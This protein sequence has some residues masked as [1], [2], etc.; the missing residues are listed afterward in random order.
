MQNFRGGDRGAEDAEDGTCVK[1]TGH[2][3]GNKIG[4]HALHHF[5][6]R[7]N[8]GDEI[9]PRRA[10]GCRIKPNAFRRNERCW[11]NAG[12]GMREHAE[13]VPLAAC[14]RHLGVGECRSA[15]R[16]L[17]AVHHNGRAVADARFFLGDQRNRFFAGWQLRAHQ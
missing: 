14:E 4:R 2:D 12:A 3:G 7:G 13:G 17:R 9:T 5:I 15:F 1:S 11:N 8:S 6:S 10:A 16:D